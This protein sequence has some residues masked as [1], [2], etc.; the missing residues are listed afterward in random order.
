MR[1]DIVHRHFWS[2]AMRPSASPS[3]I[4]A[5]TAGKWFVNVLWQVEQHGELEWNDAEASAPQQPAGPVGLKVH[6]PLE[7]GHFSSHRSKSVVDLKRCDMCFECKM[8]FYALGAK[9]ALF[10][11]RNLHSSTDT[12]HIGSCGYAVLTSCWKRKGRWQSVGDREVC[13]E[14]EERRER[15]QRL[16]RRHLP[17]E[18]I[19]PSNQSW[20]ALCRQAPFKSP[21]RRG[22]NRGRAESSGG[23]G[24]EEREKKSGRR[25]QQVNPKVSPC[26][27]PQT[28]NVWPPQSCHQRLMSAARKVVKRGERRSGRTRGR[29]SPA[30]KPA[31]ICS[32]FQRQIWQDGIN[33]PLRS[34]SFTNA[35]KCR[36]TSSAHIYLNMRFLRSHHVLRHGGFYR[37]TKTNQHSNNSSSCCHVWR[38]S[39][40]LITAYTY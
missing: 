20:A 2:W 17:S 15:W 37:L 28:V 38:T 29:V 6:L 26:H 18:P 36:Y 7:T 14:E 16:R 3:E 30:G 19:C 1:G 21:K 13:V 23:W 22:V 27:L 31:V 39:A 4:Q 5:T 9:E 33:L 25:R 35:V 11:Y 34:Q 12:Y 32:H 8:F 10:P 24:E 40:P